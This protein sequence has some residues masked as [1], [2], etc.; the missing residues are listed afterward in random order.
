M[1]EAT[2][3]LGTNRLTE[4]EREKHLRTQ[5]ES[6]LALNVF[7]EGLDMLM[8]A[9]MLM[10]QKRPWTISRILRWFGWR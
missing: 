5:M 8:A 10:D 7:Y 2:A 9:Y 1:G 4:E 6:M 3:M